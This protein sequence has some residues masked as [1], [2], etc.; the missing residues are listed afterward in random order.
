MKLKDSLY[1]PFKHWAEGGSVYITSDPHFGDGAMYGKIIYGNAYDIFSNEA[2]AAIINKKL[3]KNDTLII[4]GDI[5]DIEGLKLLKP[6]YKVLILG[7]HDAGRSVYE[8]YFNEIYNGPLIISEKII[9]SHEPIL[10]PGMIN[11]HGHI[12][13]PEFKI[14]LNNYIS[15]NCAGNIVSFEKIN[16]KHLIEAG[17]LKEVPSIHRLAIERQK[18]RKK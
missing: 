11:I 6:C 15:I 13:D 7:N 9:L 1:T 10:I 4:L 17:V 12:H 8:E 18:E 14:E 2:R 3:Y 5:G 16:L